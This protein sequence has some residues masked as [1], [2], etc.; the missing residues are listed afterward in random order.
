MRYS[1]LY[2]ALDMWP[3]GGLEAEELYLTQRGWLT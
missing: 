3:A 2:N 1:L